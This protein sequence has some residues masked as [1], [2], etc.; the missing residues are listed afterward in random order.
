MTPVAGDAGSGG[1]L[2]TDP[3]PLVLTTSPTFATVGDSAGRLDAAGFRLERHPQLGA[4]YAAALPDAAYIVAGLPPVTAETLAR[5][6]R[7]KG[8]FKHGV[9]VDSIDIDAAT[10]AGVAVCSTPGANA[11]AVAELALGALFALGRNTVHG[12]QSVTAGHWDRRRGIEIAGRTLGI[13][14]F[15]QIGQRLARLAV[16]VG[17]RVVAHDPF[18]DARAA[19]EIGAGLASFD[20]VIGRADVLSLHLAATPGTAGMIDARVLAAMRPGAMV[21]N[22]ARGS[23]LDL[24]ALAEAL[25]SGHLRGAAIDAFPVEPPDIR[26]PIFAAPGVLFSPHSGADTE[27]SVARM[28]GMVLDDLTT[29]HT[30]GMPARALNGA[31]IQR[32]RGA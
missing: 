10:A 2:R 31:Q 16:G 26:H 15:G 24:D 25:R 3:R 4:A 27:E 14:G 7:L 21:M 29:L 28:S 5:A 1:T 22:F 20:E 11:Q 12:H 6:P 23:L 8:I 32:Q 17:M 9:G 18:P 13:L 30:G 19:Q